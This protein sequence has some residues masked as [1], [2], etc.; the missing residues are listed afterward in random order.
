MPLEINRA[1]VLTLW[2]AV[3]AER[4]G[5]PAD[6]ALTLGRAVAGS[7]ARVKAR[8]IGREER[9][10]DRD[11]D[12]PGL[13]PTAP[14]VLL[15]KTIWLLPTTDGE[16]RAADGEQP[17]D[18]AAVQRYLAKAFSDHLDEVRQA[19]DELASHYEPAELNRIGFRLYEKFRPDVPYGNEGWGKRAVLDVEMI[20]AAT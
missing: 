7:A 6:T 18:P 9:K 16:L 12:R 14:A 10:A 11:A 2:A 19:M 3:V 20:R 15:G 1:P 13:R 17:A 4:L 8:N 5:H